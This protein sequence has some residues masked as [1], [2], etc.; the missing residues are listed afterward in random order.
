[1]ER[2]R[3]HSPTHTVTADGGGADGAA[4]AAVSSERGQ[5][6]WR[7]QVQQT[8]AFWLPIALHASANAAVAPSHYRLD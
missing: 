2:R 3:Q 4:A 6:G 8:H 5:V 7:R 1:M